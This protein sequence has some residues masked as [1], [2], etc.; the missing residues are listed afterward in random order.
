[1]NAQS[2]DLPVATKDDEHSVDKPQDPI[3]SNTNL[4]KQCSCSEIEMDVDCVD[5]LKM[6][7]MVLISPKIL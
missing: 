7:S 6:M 1:M 4:E 3:V 5:V 2:S